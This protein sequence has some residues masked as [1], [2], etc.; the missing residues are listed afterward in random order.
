MHLLEDF[1]IWP[2][3]IVDANGPSNIVFSWTLY[4]IIL[5]LECKFLGRCEGHSKT[6]YSRINFTYKYPPHEMPLVSK[7]KTNKNMKTI[8]SSIFRPSSWSFW[9]LTITKVG[10]IRSLCILTTYRSLSYFESLIQVH[11]RGRHI[12]GQ[13]DCTWTLLRHL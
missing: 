7:A 3:L 6:M 13:L 12:S 8:H 9:R 4:L 5:Y 10:G 11:N 2:C 1:R